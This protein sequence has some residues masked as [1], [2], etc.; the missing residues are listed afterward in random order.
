M[1]QPVDDD[2]F[3]L[4]SSILER[5][6]AHAV[7]VFL[8]ELESVGDDGPYDNRLDY[9]KSSYQ[10]KA[11]QPVACKYCGIMISDKISQT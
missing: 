2:L 1:K 3:D 6:Q 4:M 9:L 8:A 7:V 11:K 5:E 10:V